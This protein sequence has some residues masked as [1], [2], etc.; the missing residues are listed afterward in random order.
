M[1]QIG[2]QE[3]ASSVFSFCNLLI[4][5]ADSGDCIVQ[6]ILPAERRGCIPGGYPGGC[7]LSDALASDTDDENAISKARKEA[8]QR[9]DHSK[10]EKAK[11]LKPKKFSG[12]RYRKTPYSQQSS[13]PQ[14]HQHRTRMC[15][16]YGIGGHLQE[17]CPNRFYTK[18]CT[19]I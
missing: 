9:A 16:S 12:R 3:K 2:Y 5:V 15:Y 17:Y 6:R 7:Y 18:H 13:Q 19:R 14:Y 11:K 8:R 1:Q 10:N 4:R